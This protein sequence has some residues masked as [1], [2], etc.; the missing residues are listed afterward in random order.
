M[1]LLRYFVEPYVEIDQKSVQSIGVQQV[2]LQAAG[3]EVSAARPL[4]H[5]HPRPRLH[6]SA[7]ALVGAS[8]KGRRSPPASTPGGFGRPA[9][10][11]QLPHYTL[12]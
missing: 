2:V 9:S 8:S 5:A 1:G 11:T 6:S 10:L 3:Q 4:R 12:L 7:L